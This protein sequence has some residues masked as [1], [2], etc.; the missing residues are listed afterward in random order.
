MKQNLLEIKK[1]GKKILE[2]KSFGIGCDL[3]EWGKKLRDKKFFAHEVKKY[4]TF[5][6]DMSPA[7]NSFVGVFAVGEGWHNYHHVF[8]WDYKAA[9][10]GNYSVNLTTGFI[11]LFA[12]IGTLLQLKQL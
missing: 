12:K 1:V 2:W 11:D 10:L 6:S 9:E 5:Y 3:L 4:F 8:P 7:E